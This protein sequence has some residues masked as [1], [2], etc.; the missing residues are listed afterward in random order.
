MSG[1]RSSG[2]LM[3]RPG[4]HD[5]WDPAVLKAQLGAWPL[6]Q[7]VR[8][9]KLNLG[10]QAEV[11]LLES[12]SE[13]W[14]AKFA[15]QHQHEF[16]AGLRAAEIVQEA[17]VRSGQPL[18]TRRGALTVMVEGPPGHQ[19]PLAVL[20]FVLGSPAGKLMPETAGALLGRV[21]SALMEKGSGLVT[22]RDLVS[23]LAVSAEHS[24][25]GQYEWVRAS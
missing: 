17:G 16:E 15:Y 9:R 24:D 14:V 10:V 20:E 18:R 3:R 21:H 7:R 22:P 13:R 1:H 25:L 12:G 19:H 6:P 23:D 4:A 11:W 2:P 5:S 8:A